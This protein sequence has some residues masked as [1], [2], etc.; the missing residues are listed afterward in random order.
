MLEN[1]DISGIDCGMN[2]GDMAED[3]VDTDVHLFFSEVLNEFDVSVANC[4]HEGVPIVRSGEL[5]DEMRE[6][7]EEIDDL[8]GV[9]FLLI[10]KRVPI[11]QK[12]L[13]V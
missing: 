12:I 6:R 13:L 7:V 2:H 5:V 4:V 10:V 8:F 11:Q 3:A 1:L 9:S